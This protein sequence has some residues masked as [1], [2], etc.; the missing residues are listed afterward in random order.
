[1]HQHLQNS[2]LGCEAQ[3][4][5]PLAPMIPALPV[6]RSTLAGKI[7]N[8]ASLAKSPG[9]NHTLTHTGAPCSSA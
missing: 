2:D 6:T 1:M 5:S 3:I 7:A 4:H 9:P 8:V